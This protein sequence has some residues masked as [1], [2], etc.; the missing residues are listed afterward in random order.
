MSK[1]VKAAAPI[2]LVEDNAGDVYLP[3][4]PFKLVTTVGGLL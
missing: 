1:A 2:V 4:R 3:K